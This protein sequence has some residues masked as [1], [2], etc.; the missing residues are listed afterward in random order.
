MKFLLTNSLEKYVWNRGDKE[1]I[2]KKNYSNAISQKSISK[3]IAVLNFFCRF[4]FPGSIKI[5]S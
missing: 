5:F 4:P 2:N 3:R 1:R